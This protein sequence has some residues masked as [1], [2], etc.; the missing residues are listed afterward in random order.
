MKKR[1]G[2]ADGGF[3]AAMGF[4]AIVGTLCGTF[5]YS[6]GWDA[7]VRDAVAGRATVIEKPDGTTEAVKVKAKEASK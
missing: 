3:F 6:S 1:R 5:G 7:G 4:A 2:E